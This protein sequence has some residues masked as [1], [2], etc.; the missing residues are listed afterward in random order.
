MTRGRDTAGLGLHAEFVLGLDGVRVQPVHL[1]AREL[2]FGDQPAGSRL[3][4]LEP[5][6]SGYF[7]EALPVEMHCHSLGEVDFSEFSA[8]DLAEVNAAAAFEGV[9]CVP[10]VYLRRDQIE[11]FVLFMKHFRDM[12]ERGRLAAEWPDSA[13][14]MVPCPLAECS[15]NG[16]FGMS[17]PTSGTAQSPLS[18][19]AVRARRAEAVARAGGRCCLA[20]AGVAA[21]DPDVGSARHYQSTTSHDRAINPL[22]KLLRSKNRAMIVLA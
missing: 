11:P 18:R 1:A 12:R 9:A 16:Q 5:E 22:S 20:G 21:D 7:V 19:S 6:V 14:Q 13:T 17:A 8:L 10:T 3:P 4:R 15:G 2:V